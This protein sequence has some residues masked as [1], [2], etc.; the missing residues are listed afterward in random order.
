VRKKKVSINFRLYHLAHGVI[1]V[2]HVEAC[3]STV[4]NLLVASLA[5]EISFARA[6]RA[7][8]N[9]SEG[10]APLTVQALAEQGSAA[11]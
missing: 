5:S 3:C 7:F 1:G 6:S 2:N 4:L 8:D 10:N 9:R 11:E